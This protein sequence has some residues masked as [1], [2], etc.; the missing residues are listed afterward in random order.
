MSQTDVH[1]CRFVD[2]TPHSITSLAFSH[3][4]TRKFS[5]N[6]LRLAVGRNNGD[7]ELWNPRGKWIHETTLQ[8]SK[9]RSV[10]ALAWSSIE[11]DESRVFSIGGTSTITEW[12][13]RTGRVLK[14]TDCNAAVV[15]SIAT[16]PD[17]K[18]LAVGCDDGTVVVLD[19]SGG[20]GS[21]E[22]KSFLQRQ[23]ARVLSLCWAGDDKIVGGCADG[24]VRVWDAND[25]RLLAT[26]RVDKSKIEST[27]V[28]S[29][30]YLS[31]LNQIVSGDSTGSVKFWDLK[32]TTLLQ[33]FKVHEADVLTLT[34]DLANDSV[35]T[36]GVDRKIYKFQQVEHQGQ[37]KWL[38]VSNRLFHSNDVRAMV[39][40]ESKNF[41]FLVSGGVEKSI[42]VS[43]VK[44]FTDGQYR[45]LSII[46]QKQVVTLNR[47]EKLIALWQDQTVKIWRLVM[48]SQPTDDV[49]MSEDSESEDLEELKPSFEL[50]SKLTLADEDNITTCAISEDG[51]LL[52]VGRL[53]TTKLFQLKQKSRASNKLAVS[54]I[55][56]PAL[57][58]LGSKHLAFYGNTHIITT[59]PKNEVYKL[60]LEDTEADPVEFT[61][62][63]L[64]RS[65][66]KPAYSENISQIN[67][68]HSTLLVTRGSA[69]DTINLDMTDVEDST[70]FIRLSSTIS[71]VT[72]SPSRDSVIVITSES[73]IYEFALSDAHLTTW[74]K[75]NSEFLPQQY[76]S[77]TEP[78][79]GCFFSNKLWVYG[80]TW[81]ASFDLEHNIPVQKT[82]KKRGHNGALLIGHNTDVSV[83]DEDEVMSDGEDVIVPE[84]A[85][86]EREKNAKTDSHAFAL[87]QKYQGVLFADMLGENEMLIVERPRTALKQPPAFK[88]QQYRV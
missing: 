6:D 52:A 11:G 58:A 76:L 71:Q 13:L 79:V 24:R 87:T 37:K 66:S 5:P 21:C 74:S 84:S 81:V 25:R 2:Y 17:Q 30:L 88:L 53:N 72:T 28:W 16:S 69:I 12:D 45:K 40:Y 36:A 83:D 77:Q 35:F 49:E 80:A 23:D 60:S 18:S 62:S 7:V 9:D 38:N 27:L 85:A 61:L 31:E 78:P 34:T 56:Y 64:P 59:T 3:A 19:I 39:S 1:R 54:K 14:E 65:K 20:V 47:R 41:N 8:G 70:P 43:G 44:T 22:H 46:P 33:S 73:K 50:V 48:R 10:E 57:N 32:H 82:S 29:V 86:Q 15:W 42:V 67:L 75:S 55:D 26:M 68:H 51:T 63:E 4:S